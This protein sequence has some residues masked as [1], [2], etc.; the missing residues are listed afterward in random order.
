MRLKN[1]VGIITGSGSGIGRATAHLFAREGCKVVIADIDDTAGARVAN[2]IE[3][4]HG[5][6]YFV[7]TDVTKSDQ[8]KN[9]ISSAVQHFGGI[10]ILFNNAGTEGNVQT[11]VETPETSWDRTL[12]INLKSVYLGCH[13]AIPEMMKRGG[14][15]I[16]NTS[17][18]DGAVSAH[19]HYSAYCA[20][21]AGVLGLTRALALEVAQHKNTNI[22]TENKTE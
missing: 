3:E 22:N 13:H 19:S 11:L 12:A 10:D 20:S 9:L 2:E 17:S 6:A 14:G 1:K 18:I 21:K 4:A 5:E 15:S 16:L 7:H 8:V